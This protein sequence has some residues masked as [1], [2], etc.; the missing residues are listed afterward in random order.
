MIS[1]GLLICSFYLKKK[2][3]RAENEICELNQEYEYDENVY[4]DF[5][6]CLGDLLRIS[7]Y[8]LMMRR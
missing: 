1:R 4:A 5:L 2:Y 6:S 7:V 8:S 3:S